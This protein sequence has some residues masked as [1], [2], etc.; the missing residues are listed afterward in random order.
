LEYFS[1]FGIL[2][3]E[4]SGNP[5]AGYQGD[6]IGR[7]LAYCVNAFFWAV[8]EN[9]ITSQNN[10]ATSFRGKSCVLIL[11]KKRVGL[12]FGQFFRGLVWSPC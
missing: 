6:Q 8:F 4:K 3:Q 5:D 11:T 1:R 2:Y 12:R 7:M 9:C 10:R